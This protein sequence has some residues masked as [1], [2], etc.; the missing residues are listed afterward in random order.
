MFRRAS[1]WPGWHSGLE[2]APHTQYGS[3]EKVSAHPTASSADCFNHS[4][5]SFSARFAIGNSCKQLLADFI[6]ALGRR[7]VVLADAC[8]VQRGPEAEFCSK[9]LGTPIVEI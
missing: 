4:I 5:D 7:P 8:P 2:Q 6:D 3:D 9:L 1:S